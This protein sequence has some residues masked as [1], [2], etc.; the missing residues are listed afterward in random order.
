MPKQT[1][2]YTVSLNS[3]DDEVS[4]RT[5]AKALTP[6]Q[7]A[8]LLEDYA[9]AY[10]SDFNRGKETGKFLCRA[11]RTLQRSVIVELCGIICGLANQTHTDPR[12]ASAIALAKNIEEVVN[13]RGFG[14]F[15]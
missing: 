15:V 2:R 10:S 11:H 7:F 14:A 13:E 12:N 6:E 3:G 5:I 9:N 1:S 8:E 4:V